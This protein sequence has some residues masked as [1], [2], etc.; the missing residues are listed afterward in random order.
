MQQE[1]IA[2]KRNMKNY[3]VR[4]YFTVDID[5]EGEAES[6]E[7]ADQKADHAIVNINAEEF[8]KEAYAVR[9]SIEQ[10]VESAAV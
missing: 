8:L 5:W 7:Q 1:R 2:M 6:E 9:R 10:Q 3:H 4:T